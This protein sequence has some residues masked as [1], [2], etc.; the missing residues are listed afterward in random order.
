MQS[1]LQISLKPR[2]RAADD[3]SNVETTVVKLIEN[4]KRKGGQEGE[5]VLHKRRKPGAEQ[6]NK[7]ALPENLNY[8]LYQQLKDKLAL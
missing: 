8:F 5:P 3:R 1:S 4:R 2:K 7:R 6:M